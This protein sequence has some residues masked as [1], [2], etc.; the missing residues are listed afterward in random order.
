MQSLSTNAFF[1]SIKATLSK[2]R[3]VAMTAGILL[4]VCTPF[5]N[6][7]AIAQTAPTRT[8]HRTTA[9]VRR[10]P[11]RTTASPAIP[12]A[13]DRL[14]APT[15]FIGT[16]KGGMVHSGDDVLIGYELQ[17]SAGGQGNWKML[18]SSYDSNTDSHTPTVLEQGNLTYSQQNNNITLQLSGGSQPMTLE[19]ESVNNYTLM[20][21]QVTGTD[22]FFR[23]SKN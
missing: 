4:A 15:S 10:V 22:L 18:G 21:G 20:A 9:P 14:A 12:A 3:P 13:T 5:E 11:A 7:S 2:A 23:F 8:H 16:W 17:L 6:S 19:G 1:S